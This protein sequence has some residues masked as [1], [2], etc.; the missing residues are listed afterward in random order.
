MNEPTEVDGFLF[1]RKCPASGLTNTDKKCDHEGKMGAGV[2][3]VGDL[4]E[5]K[6]G[7]SQRAL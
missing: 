2:L 4:A 7:E 1:M 5:R 6:L 3:E